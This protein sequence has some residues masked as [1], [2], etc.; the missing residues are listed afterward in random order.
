MV[1]IGLPAISRHPEFD[2]AA[3]AAGADLEPELPLAE[4]RQLAEE[5]L[6]AAARS[7]NP[8]LLDSHRLQLRSA[9]EAGV[10]RPGPQF[11]W[12]SHVAPS[13]SRSTGIVWAATAGRSRAQQRS[14]SVFNVG[15]R[16]IDNEAFECHG[17]YLLPDRIDGLTL[18]RCTFSSCQNPHSAGPAARPVMRNVRV[19]R[20]HASACSL[21]PAVLEESAVDTAWFHRG[22]W[23]PQRLPGWA[24]RHVVIRGNITGSVAFTPGPGWPLAPNRRA[25]DD[26]YVIANDRYYAGVD[27]ALDISEANFTSVTIWSGIPS[28]LVRL[29]PATQVVVKRSALLDDRWRDLELGAWRLALEDFLVAGFEDQILVACK[30]GRYYEREMDAIRCLRSTGLV[31]A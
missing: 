28:R 12:F 16:I 20:C 23:G 6:P 27:W 2:V 3:G 5:Q 15:M 26:P 7:T 19:V 1:W 21:P 14:V 13:E 18:R 30:R 4:L 9:A 24:F 22:I 17:S 10:D 29:D 25:T 8:E 11:A 31:D